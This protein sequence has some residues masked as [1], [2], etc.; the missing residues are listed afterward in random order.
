MLGPL[1]GRSDELDLLVRQWKRARSGEGQVLLLSGEP[2]IG[3]SRLTAALLERL[4]G[5]PHGL[6]SY[7][8]SPQHVDSAYH[9]VIGLVERAAEFNHDD[10]PEQ[11]LDKLDA[12]LA[13]NVVPKS[14]AALFADMLFLRQDGRYPV[15][16]LTP[17]Q[18]RERTLRALVGQVEMLA[19][20]SPLLIVFEDVHWCDPTTLEFLNR[21]VAAVASLPVFAIV[22]C[23]PEFNS[24]WASQS[25]VV[26]LRLDRLD[27]EDAKS[28]AAQL[29]G[30][31]ALPAN[32]LAAIA[33]RADGNPLFVE[34]ITKAVIEAESEGTSR[35]AGQADTQQAPSLP[36]S[37]H[38]SL[39]ARLD[40][41]GTEAKEIA[42]IGA[43][44]GREFSQFLLAAVASRGDGELRRSLDRLIEAGLVFRHGA[45][46]Q[47]NY[48]FKHALVRDAA[49]GTL[50]RGAAGRSTFVS[51]RSSKSSARTSARYLP[52]ASRITIRRQA[53]S[54]ARRRCGAWPVGVPARARRWRKRKL[55]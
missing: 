24:P 26:Y 51:P 5:E 46:S 54:N 29:V 3:K 31:R 48:V 7:S 55:N 16:D 28:I 18:Q 19:Q 47:V 42:Q 25:H 2:G 50:L 13:A 44:I 39:M 27:D 12:Y 30:E 49:Y 43:A 9:P 10:A 8:C 14:D 4:A 52:R 41:L 34:E 32:V 38:A 17:E 33:A 22:T 45:P 37:L 35:S 36:A 21:T 53:P 23:R 40:R 20:H 15:Q 1:V 6:L 11:R